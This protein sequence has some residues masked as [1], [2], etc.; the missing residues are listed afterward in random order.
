M[1]LVACVACLS[2]SPEV[3]KSKAEG[4]YNLILTCPIVYLAR[5]AKCVPR[6]RTDIFATVAIYSLPSQR[7]LAAAHSTRNYRSE[8]ILVLNC[9][10]IFYALTF[11][12]SY[13]YVTPSSKRVVPHLHS[14]VIPLL[15]I[16]LG[17]QFEAGPELP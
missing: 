12:A 3:L 17:G 6:V 13:A 2:F 9:D 16:F 15:V 14:A 7:C 10:V 1:C 4:H 11:R 5:V 8:H